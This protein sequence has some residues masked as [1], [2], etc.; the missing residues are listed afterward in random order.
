MSKAEQ[1][2]CLPPCI[3]DSAVYTCN[4][5][6]PPGWT[7]IALV[8]NC[9]RHYWLYM[10]TAVSEVSRSWGLPQGVQSVLLSAVATHGS[11]KPYR[12]SAYLASLKARAVDQEVAA[13]RRRL[14]QLEEQLAA[15]QGQV[16][17]PS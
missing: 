1:S 15:M 6:L 7:P 5:T 3:G 9:C 10:T 12:N 2:V 4:C 8:L 11:A 13:A 16:T 17:A 14:A